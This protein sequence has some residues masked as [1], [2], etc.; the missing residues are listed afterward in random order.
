MG[1]PELPTPSDSRPA[2]ATPTPKNTSRLVQTPEDQMEMTTESN[3]ESVYV[4][5]ENNS[6]QAR[7]KVESVSGAAG[8]ATGS[9]D[10]H[11]LRIVGRVRIMNILWKT[12]Q[13][14]AQELYGSH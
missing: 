1:L 11:N 8:V 14:P 12:L 4:I 6:R 9:T 3:P 7:D 10:V 5:S 2:D 13:E